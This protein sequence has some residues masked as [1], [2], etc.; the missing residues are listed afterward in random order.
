MKENSKPNKNFILI[1]L[2][3]LVAYLVIRSEIN[4]MHSIDYA[5]KQEECHAKGKCVE[6]GFLDNRCID[7]SELIEDK[8]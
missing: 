1:L 5:N 7:C 6:S 3:I 2:I 4:N 8:N